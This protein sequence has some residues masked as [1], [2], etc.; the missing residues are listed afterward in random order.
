[1][2]ATSALDGGAVTNLVR[3]PTLAQATVA[4]LTGAAVFGL[5]QGWLFEHAAPMAGFEHSGWFL[6]SGLGVRVIGRTFIVTGIL[7]GLLRQSGLIDAALIVSGA[8]LAMMI[9]LFSI[10]PGTIFPIVVAFGT[11]VVFGATAIG[12]LAGV[13]VR[14]LL[15]VALKRF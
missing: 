3:F 1:M 15:G 9:V 11:A 4:L 5:A 13:A 7:A 8:V 12:A 14:R 6:N 2:A 10:G